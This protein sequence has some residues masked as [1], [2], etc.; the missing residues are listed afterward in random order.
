MYKYLLS[1]VVSQ[2]STHFRVFFCHGL[3][4]YY[5]CLL[6]FLHRFFEIDSDFS[7][8]K[9]REIVRLHLAQIV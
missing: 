9:L 4:R 3:F 8:Y 6:M 5:W 7:A 1:Y 2:H